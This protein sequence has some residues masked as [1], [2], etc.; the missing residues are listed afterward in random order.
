MDPL[1]TIS[2]ESFS[3]IWFWIITSV[4][5]SVTCHITLGVPYDLLTRAERQGGQAATDVDRLA[6]IHARRLSGYFEKSHSRV[7][8]VTVLTFVLAILGTFGLYYSYELATAIFVLMVP[9]ILVQILAVRLAFRVLR[10]G[11]EGE[12]LR[13]VLFKRRFW[14]QII[15]LISIVTIAAA[16]FLNFARNFA[17]WY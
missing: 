10:D 5:W 13:S 16:A 1:L 4:A 7:I 8:G 6:Q 11:L 14:N 12:A 2:F 9:L 15:G 3:S 17:I